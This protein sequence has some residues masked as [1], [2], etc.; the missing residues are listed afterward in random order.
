MADLV[1]QRASRMRCTYT[2]ATLVGHDVESSHRRGTETGVLFRL[3]VCTYQQHIRLIWW[4][5]E[6]SSSSNLN[7]E[8]LATVMFAHRSSDSFAGN[9]AI[10]PTLMDMRNSKGKT[11]E[12]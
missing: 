1:V 4:K 3:Q 10:R 6:V 8:Y 5:Q 12:L 7:Q 9:N 2:Q 11:E